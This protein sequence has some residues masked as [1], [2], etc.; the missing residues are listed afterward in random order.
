[1]QIL[2]TR[3]EADAARTAE[4]VR[5]LGHDVLIAPL[6]RVEIVVADFGGRFDAVLTTSANAARAI[7]SHA[8][9]N[10]LI[11][12]PCLTV[13]NRSADAA[14]AAGFTRVESAGGALAD[15][16]RLAA[17]RHAHGRV[18]YLAGEDRAGDLAGELSRHGVVVDT[19][20]IYRAVALESL[21][22][23]ILSAR[24]DGVLHY[25]RRSVTTLLR[26][27]ERADALNAVLSLAHYCLSAEVA[28]PLREAGAQ[29]IAIAASPT[30]SALLTLLK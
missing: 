6:L 21:P 29:R 16:V 26:L 1:M 12:L 10:E 5:A 7:A 15:L 27:A 22:A 25:S 3:P 4:T 8:R 14:R 23:E 11:T 20:V 13:G 24:L 17:Q 2:V 28:G 19:A 9:A 30:E 18:L